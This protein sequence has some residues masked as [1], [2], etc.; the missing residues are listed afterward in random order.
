MFVLE[1][2]LNRFCCLASKVALAVSLVLL[3]NFSLKPNEFSI[4]TNFTFIALS[5][6]FL[7]RLL[8]FLEHNQQ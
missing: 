5:F 8:K 6:Q 1:S 2:F 7:V 3:L 4:V